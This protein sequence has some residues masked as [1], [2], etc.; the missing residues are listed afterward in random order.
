ML[1]SLNQFFKVWRGLVFKDSFSFSTTDEDTT[2]QMRLLNI[3][4]A[5]IISVSIIIIP[6]TSSGLSS[7]I[8]IYSS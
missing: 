8:L 3:I 5:V 2:I 4:I 6:K 1:V 7:T